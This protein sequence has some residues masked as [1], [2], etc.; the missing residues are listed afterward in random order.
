[1]ISNNTASNNLNESNNDN[2]FN[3]SVSNLDPERIDRKDGGKY[4]YHS[5]EDVGVQ[6]NSNEVYSINLKSIFFVFIGNN[7]MG[8]YVNEDFPTSAWIAS[9]ITLALLG[10]F[11]IFSNFTIVIVYIRKPAVSFQLCLELR[12]F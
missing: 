3:T 11:G 2:F 5:F 1:M 9:S 6:G 7:S 8:Y 4:K 10:G 12:Q